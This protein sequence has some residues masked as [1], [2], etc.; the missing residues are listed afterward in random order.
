MLVAALTLGEV[1]VRKM[2]EKTRRSNI[3][4]IAL[5]ILITALAKV[6]SF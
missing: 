5:F 1:R 3:N 4:D 6:S 2:E